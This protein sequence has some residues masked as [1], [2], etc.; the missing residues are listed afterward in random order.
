MT[1]EIAAGGADLGEREEI[2]PPDQLTWAQAQVTN[3]RG[4]VTLAAALVGE[5]PVPP[6][7]V[8]IQLIL[9]A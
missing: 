6:D 8:D 2:R 7:Y 4:Q 5:L 9:A 1:R 3:S